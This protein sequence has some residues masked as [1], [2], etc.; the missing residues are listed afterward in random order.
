M[1]LQERRGQ[2]ESEL[3]GEARGRKWEGSGPEPEAEIGFS[4]GAM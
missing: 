3:S 2:G 1:K 4:T